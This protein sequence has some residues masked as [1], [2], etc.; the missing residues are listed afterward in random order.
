M[1]AQV[2]NS[3][4]WAARAYS[5]RDLVRQGVG[6]H[7]SEQRP[8]PIKLRGGRIQG[9]CLFDEQLPMREGVRAAQT[10]M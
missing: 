7:S 10:L 2:Q 3:L 5:G 8:I 6:L 4:L 9:A 1:G